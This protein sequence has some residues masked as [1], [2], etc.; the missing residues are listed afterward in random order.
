[1]NIEKYCLENEHLKFEV[2]NY[3]AIITSIYFKKH[4]LET[5][6]SYDSVDDYLYDD[7]YLGASCVGPYAG[8]IK[9]ATYKIDEQI[10]NLD[11][12]DEQNSLHGG[13]NGLHKTFFNVEVT[14]TRAV[15]TCN[16]EELQI[17]IV[18]TLIKSML[19]QE[20]YATTT[21]A[22]VFN[23]T[24][25][26]Y[27]KLENES[28]KE[29]TLNLNASDVYY[30]TEDS[31]PLKKLSLNKTPFKSLNG[32]KQ[33]K[34]VDDEQFNFTK[35][36]D[37]PFKLRG[38]E[39]TFSDTKGHTLHINTNAPFAVVYTANYLASKRIINGV[40]AFDYMGI[41]IETQNLP[42]GVNMEN[43]DSSILYPNQTFYLLNTYH[44]TKNLK[45]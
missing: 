14:E 44:L 11:K 25:H 31:I 34:N 29:Y 10:I 39:I 5:V 19:K 37:H 38:E 15:L 42:N 36:I 43:E 12:N 16:Y 26:T 22:T 20:I 8:R 32:S 41:C 21:K 18:F 27:F 9:D 35:Y 23:P 30:V 1:M 3:G 6:L 7:K 13:Y 24:N 45:K 28:C 2:L 33:I 17:K 4:N 40:K